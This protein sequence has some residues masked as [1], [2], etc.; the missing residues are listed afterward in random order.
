MARSS[1]KMFALMSNLRRSKA[2]FAKQGL[3]TKWMIRSSGTGE[4][5]SEPFIIYLRK[6]NSS[7][8]N[9]DSMTPAELCVTDPVNVSI[10]FHTKMDGHIHETDQGKRYTTVWRSVGPLLEN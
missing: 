4:W 3:R 2:Y 1:K 9:V 10:H 7:A 5:Y 6:I 8:P